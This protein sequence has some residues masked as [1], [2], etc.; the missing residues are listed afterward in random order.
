MLKFVERDVRR[1]QETARSLTV[2]TCAIGWAR[3]G[4]VCDGVQHYVVGE[5]REAP[6]DA[7]L[8]RSSVAA[9]LKPEY[10]TQLGNDGKAAKAGVVLVHTHPGSQPLDHFSAVDDGGEPPLAA[11]FGQRLPGQEHFAALVTA[12]GL[13]ARKLGP[14]AEVE[15]A[16]VGAALKLPGGGGVTANPLFDRQVRAFGEAG[17]QALGRLRVAIVGL[18]G[19]GSIV[20]QQLSYLGVRD[21]IL[22]DPDTVDHTNLNRLVGATVADVGAAKVDVASRQIQAIRQGASCNV[23]RGDVTYPE[24]ANALLAADFIFGCTDS[25]AS[26]AVIN[27]LAYQ[28]FIPVIDMGVG[29]GADAG[30]VTYIA[31]RVQMLSPGLPCLVCTEKLDGEQVRRE[32]MTEEQRK[33]D[34]YITGERVVQ[35]AVISLNSAVVSAAVTMF[36]AAVT[37][38]PSQARMLTF[39]VMRGAVKPVVADPRPHCIVCSVQG[40]LGRGSSWNLPTREGKA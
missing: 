7:Y 10:L 15:C 3:P 32:L 39:D 18:G 26:R 1:L 11:Y 4:A 9:T 30:R 25:M 14:G 28:H 35:P 2:E 21:F 6:E 13:R 19:T 23:L 33:Q 17:Q 40:A 29:I 38:L 24:V 34:P 27:Q 31:G 36:L 8:Q 37:G 12:N 20:A 16:W 5:L 22:I